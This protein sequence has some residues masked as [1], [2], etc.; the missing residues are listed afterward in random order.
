VQEETA[1]LENKRLYAYDV[2]QRRF[3]VVYLYLAYSTFQPSKPELAQ[4]CQQVFLQSLLK[5]SRISE[6]AIYNSNVADKSPRVYYNGICSS[7]QSRCA[8]PLGQPLR[9]QYRSSKLGRGYLRPRREPER[10]TKSVPRLLQS[11]EKWQ[12]LHPK[13]GCRKEAPGGASF[14]AAARRLGNAEI[15]VARAADLRPNAVSKYC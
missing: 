3:E 4:V 12:F 9:S 2:T 13:S 10:C 14:P 6:Q 7:E 1:V 15:S 8:G 11:G 5:K